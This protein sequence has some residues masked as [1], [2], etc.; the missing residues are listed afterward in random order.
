MKYESGDIL[1]HEYDGFVN[2]IYIIVEEVKGER[3]K[4]YKVFSREHATEFVYSE[5][6]L[7]AMT[8]SGEDYRQK[9]GIK[10]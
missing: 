1:F 4:S 6:Y 2:D 3:H 10:K 9:Y 7:S 5:A 8:I